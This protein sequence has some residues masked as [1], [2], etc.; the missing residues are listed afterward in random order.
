MAWP[1]QQNIF[2]PAWTH[3]SVSLSFYIRYLANTHCYTLFCCYISGASRP[4]SRFNYVL[5]YEND[6]S[7]RTLNRRCQLYSTS[8]LDYSN[9]LHQKMIL[10]SWCHFGVMVFLDVAALKMKFSS[11]VDLSQINTD[12]FLNQ[13]RHI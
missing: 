11:L 9:K 12:V 13:V 5:K 2:L 7:L 8:W 3:W 6:P 4:W 10:L 1:I